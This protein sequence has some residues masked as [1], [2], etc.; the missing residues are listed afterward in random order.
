MVTVTIPKPRWSQSSHKLSVC[1]NES[2]LFYIAVVW[3][4]PVCVAPHCAPAGPIRI[5]LT[6]VIKVVGI[7]CCRPTILYISYPPLIFP[8]VHNPVGIIAEIIASI[9]SCHQVNHWSLV[10]GKSP[11]SMGYYRPSGVTGDSEVV[12]NTA[13]TTAY[14]PGH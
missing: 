2:V 5:R 11:L 4:V 13:V 14:H 7:Y 10:I 12:L 3:P 8:T 6:G 9:R 1:L